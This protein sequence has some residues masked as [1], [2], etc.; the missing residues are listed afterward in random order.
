[1]G[2]TLSMAAAAVKL[3]TWWGLIP[4]ITRS[5][6]ESLEGKALEVRGWRKQ[7]RV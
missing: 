1:M 6:L 4:P 5:A 2:E 3:P 7:A